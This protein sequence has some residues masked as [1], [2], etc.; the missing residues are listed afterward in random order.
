MGINV[1]VAE[2]P[3]AFAARVTADRERCEYAARD[4]VKRGEMSLDT[5]LATVKGY[6]LEHI[7]AVRQRFH[8]AIFGAPRKNAKRRHP[9]QQDARE[10]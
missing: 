2:V 3:T 6:R 4:R 7:P 8:D 9:P 1:R 10:S 5:Y